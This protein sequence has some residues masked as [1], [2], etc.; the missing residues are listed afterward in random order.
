MRKGQRKLE[1][2]KKY[3]G[4]VQIKSKAKSSQQHLT[5][6]PYA[7]GNVVPLSPIY[8]GQ[9]GRNRRF[10]MKAFCFGESLHACKCVE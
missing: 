10:T 9:R 4:K 5:F 6:I 7:L 2:I 8:L 1:K 3:K